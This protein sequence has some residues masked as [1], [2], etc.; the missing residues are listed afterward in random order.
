MNKED[1]KSESEYLVPSWRANASG[2]APVARPLLVS[3]L[4]IAII[5]PSSL[6]FLT[7]H[8]I[9]RG[10]L[11]PL[12]RYTIESGFCLFIFAVGLSGLIYGGLQIAIVH[13]ETILFHKALVNNLNV[14]QGG[15]RFLR[16]IGRSTTGIPDILAR[17]GKSISCTSGCVDGELAKSVVQVRR[18]RLQDALLPLDVMVWALPMLGFIGT[19]IGITQAIGGLGPILRA[20]TMG[21]SG[22]GGTVDTGIGGVLDGL[23]FAFDTTLVGLVLVLP[24][25][26]L[27]AWLRLKSNSLDHDITA[28]TIKLAS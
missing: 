7:G 1:F 24:V 17:L 21:P 11:A 3:A 18:A 19:V 27:G 4:T 10:L 28:H 5:W 12:A 20:V 2:V 13:A 14:P 8:E 26:L 23:T 25:N 6:P 15:S 22:G 9:W 16:M